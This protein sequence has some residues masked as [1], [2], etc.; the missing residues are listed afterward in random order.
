MWA[1]ETVPLP[2]NYGTAM[3]FADLQAKDNECQGAQADIAAF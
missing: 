1:P 2:G 3:F